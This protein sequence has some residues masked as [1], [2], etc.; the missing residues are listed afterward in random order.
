[1]DITLNHPEIKG[2]L[3]EAIKN[4]HTSREYDKNKELT[5]QQ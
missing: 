1:M 4:R 2:E 3:M 5:L